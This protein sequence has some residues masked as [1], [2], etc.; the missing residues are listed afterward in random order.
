MKL[1]FPFVNTVDAP[2]LVYLKRSIY[3]TD[4]GGH[5]DGESRLTV[6]QLP[7]RALY[8]SDADYQFILSVNS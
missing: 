1:R 6:M 4:M 2:K 7:I 5:M 8:I 3:H